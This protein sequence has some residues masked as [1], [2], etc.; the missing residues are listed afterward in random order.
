[1]ADEEVKP[2][3]TGPDKELDAIQAVLGALKDLDKEGRQRVLDY[4]FGRLGI[5]GDRGFAVLT[6]T[7]VGGGSPPPQPPASAVTDI[8]TLADQKNPRSSVEMAILVAYYL[9]ELA[10]VAERRA[11]ITS[12]DITKYFKQA[13]YKLPKRA[14]KTLFDARKSG[15][16][17]GGSETGSYKLNPVGYNL[18]THVLPPKK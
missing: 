17:D 6:P 14:I 12:A 13:G 9:A 11:E 5:R 7:V 16:M 18:V 10:P 4:V 8:R 1:M 15:Y 2:Q 3:N